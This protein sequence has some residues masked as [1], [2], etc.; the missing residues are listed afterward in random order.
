M[1]AQA[2]RGAVALDR[3]QVHQHGDVLRGRRGV[4]KERQQLLPPGAGAVTML[5][6][7]G[8]LEAGDDR[9]KSACG[10]IGRAEMP[11]IQVGVALEPFLQRHDDPRL[12]DARF[13]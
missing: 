12:A 8:P 6:T 2:K 5:E 3:E 10:A 7:G 11:K 13:S 9:I 4:R 1:M